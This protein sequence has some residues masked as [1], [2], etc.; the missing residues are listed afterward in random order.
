MARRGWTQQK[1]R[2]NPF[3][4]RLICWIALHISRGFARFWL[5]PITLY[6]FITAPGSRFGSRQYLNRVLGRSA[7]AWHIGRHMHCFAATILD[8]VYFLTD[9]HHRF[10]Y[11]IEGSELIDELVNQQQGAIL[12][13]AHVGSF[14]ALRC[15]AIT[16]H[17]LP[18]KIMMHHQHNA[19]MMKVL[20]ELNPEVANS[21]INL[22]ESDV[23]LKTKEAVDAGQLIGMLGDRAVEESHNVSC[24][25]F[26]ESVD[27]ASGPLQLAIILQVPVVMFFGIYLGWNR[28]KI[29]FKKCRC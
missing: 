15:L 28:Y 24:Q 12:L 22:S 13:G 9:Q 21:V 20:D 18:L 29:I 16:Q 19:M 8:R 3:T 4:L 6:F 1:E 14:E 25:F 5:F 23:T 27:I 2:S 10:D 26:G 11:Q 17:K 7:S